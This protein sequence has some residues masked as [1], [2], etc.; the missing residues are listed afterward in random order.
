MKKISHQNE[1]NENVEN[2]DFKQGM[3]HMISGIRAHVASNVIMANMAS[4]LTMI[5]SRFIFSHDITSYLFVNLIQDYFEENDV[6]IK[7]QI[8]KSDKKKKRNGLICFIMMLFIDQ[9]N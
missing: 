1:V 9:K 6:P 4:L 3:G 2:I 8:D 5:D 7:V